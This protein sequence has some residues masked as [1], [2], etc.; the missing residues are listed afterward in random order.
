MIKCKKPK[1]VIKD[2][3]KGNAVIN[4]IDEDENDGDMTKKR[5]QDENLESETKRRKNSEISDGSKADAE[6]SLQVKWDCNQC[7][8]NFAV[9]RNLAVHMQK[10]HG[11]YD[12]FD[13]KNESKVSKT[14]QKRKSWDCDPCNLQFELKRDL[15]THN[16]SQHRAKR[17]PGL[18][19]C[20]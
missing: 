2:F 14:P 5:K 4:D 11:V 18:R 1:S 3:N 15:G 9:K 16:E 12:H 7:G 20:K 17:A 19:Q 8:A 13:Q 10:K 6:G